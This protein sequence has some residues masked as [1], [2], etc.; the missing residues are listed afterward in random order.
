MTLQ[1]DTEK[2]GLNLIQ[3]DRTWVYSPPSRTTKPELFP[4]NEMTDYGGP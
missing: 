4:V 2:S 1:D 3:S